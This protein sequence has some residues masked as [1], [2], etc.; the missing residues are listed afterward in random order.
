MFWKE[1]NGRDRHVLG[2]GSLKRKKNAAVQHVW[3]CT[4]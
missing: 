3:A 2:N 1:Q 4:G